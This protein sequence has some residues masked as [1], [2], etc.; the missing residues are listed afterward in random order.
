MSSEIHSQGSEDFVRLFVGDTDGPAE[1]VGFFEDTG[2]TGDLY[3]SDRKQD[4]IVQHLQV[5]VDPGSLEVKEDDV[6]V[7]WSSDGSKCGVRIWG[8]MRG[9]IDMRKQRSVRAPLWNRL[10]EPIRDRNWLRGFEQYF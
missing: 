8:G 6:E 1:Y 3:V 7:F 4:K 2:E 10:S 9:I 5:Y